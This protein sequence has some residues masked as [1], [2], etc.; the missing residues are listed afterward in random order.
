MTSAKLNAQI[1]AGEDVTGHVDIVTCREVA[2]VI[3]GKSYLVAPEVAAVIGELILSFKNLYNAIDSCVDLT[4]D[5]LRT[6][7]FTLSKVG[8]A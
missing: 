7:Q 5:V 4:P 6:A 1:Q 8:A 2:I 3:E